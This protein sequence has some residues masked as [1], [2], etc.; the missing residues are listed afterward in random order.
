MSAGRFRARGG[1]FLP[2]QNFPPAPPRSA[3]WA[4]HRGEC[5]YCKRLVPGT[6]RVLCRRS[7]KQSHPKHRPARRRDDGREGR[8]VARRGRAGGPGRLR[9]RGGAAR[10]GGAPRRQDAPGTLNAR[11]LV[12][13]GG[14]LRPGEEK[15]AIAC[16]ALP[17]VAHAPIAPRLP[18]TYAEL[19]S[20]HANPFGVGI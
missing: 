3:T 7:P 12:M 14:A 1:K 13:P 16:A 11:M 20:C 10:R 17:T 2:N 15:F 5:T 4:T 8:P 9:A 6:P 19:C 18:E